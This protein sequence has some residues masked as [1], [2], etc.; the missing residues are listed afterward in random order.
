MYVAGLPWHWE[1][2]PGCLL[3]I[4]NGR[5]QFSHPNPLPRRTLPIPRDLAGE[6]CCCPSVWVTRPLQRQV[7]QFE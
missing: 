3:N 6:F 7:D 4:G 1:P 2:V 5:G